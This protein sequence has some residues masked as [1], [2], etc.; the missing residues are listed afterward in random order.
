MHSCKK[1]WEK[2]PD[3][4]GLHCHSHNIP[5]NIYFYS[6]SYESQGLEYLQSAHILIKDCSGTSH[7]ETPCIH[8]Y[9]IKFTNSISFEILIMLFL[10][11]FIVTKS[12]SFYV[13]INI[14]FIDAFIFS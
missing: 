7:T 9:F 13:I 14:C 4:G 1:V 6:N 10:L 11:I 3:R 12:Y 2:N 8:T 5:L